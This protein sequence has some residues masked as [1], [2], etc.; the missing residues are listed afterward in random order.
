MSRLFLHFVL[1]SIPNMLVSG[2]MECETE[3]K[4]G[5]GV[6]ISGSVYMILFL[7]SVE[8]HSEVVGAFTIFRNPVS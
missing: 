6:N 2:A 1:F 5:G 8:R 3:G 4:I 7:L